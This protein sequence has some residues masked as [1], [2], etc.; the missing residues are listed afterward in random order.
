MF[1]F[2][3]WVVKH[4]EIPSSI[5]SHPTHFSI[6]L[7]W[8]NDEEKTTNITLNLVQ[9]AAVGRHIPLFANDENDNP[10]QTSLVDIKVNKIIERLESQSGAELFFQFCKFYF[11]KCCIIPASLFCRQYLFIIY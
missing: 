4:S 5:S 7:E 8:S 1:L 6:N 11:A 3:E 2:T 10:V 9:S